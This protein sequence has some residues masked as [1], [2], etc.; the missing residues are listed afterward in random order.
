M[1]W[2]RCPAVRAGNNTRESVTIRDPITLET[3]QAMLELRCQLGFAR[4][5]CWDRSGSSFRALFKR[6]LAEL[7]LSGLNFRPYSLR[8]GGATY[9]MQAHGL[10]EKTLIRGRWKNSNIARLYICDGLAMLP[11]LC[12]PWRAKFCIAQY[13][14]IFVNEHQSYVDG[15]RGR[16]R[17]AGAK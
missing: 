15:M 9:E 6:I 12:M 8:R 11:R 7:D 10:M 1:G 3:V 16:K 5:P 13:S 14:S 17:K 4:T 2:C